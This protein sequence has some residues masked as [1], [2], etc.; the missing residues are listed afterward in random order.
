MKNTHVKELMTA[1]PTLI[2]PDVTLQDAA[3]QMKKIDCGVLPV[4]TADRL[5][6]VITDRDITIRAVAEGRDPTQAK[7][8]QYMSDRVYTCN[9]DNNLQEAADI[10]AKHGISRLIVDNEDGKVTG[11]LTF[12]CILRKDVDTYELSQVIKH[13]TRKNAA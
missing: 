6:G 1:Q 8:S 3:K 12:G 5:E 10:M 13:A 11:I 2:S 7:V 9:E 4:G